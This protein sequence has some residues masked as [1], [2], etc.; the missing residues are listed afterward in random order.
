MAT[1]EKGK[2]GRRRR[3]RRRIFLKQGHGYI[4]IRKKEVTL[5]LASWVEEDQKGR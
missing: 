5:L 3:R 1:P 4:L 2:A